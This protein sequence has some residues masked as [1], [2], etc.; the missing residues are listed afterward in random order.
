[1]SDLAMVTMATVKAVYRLAG[2]QCPG[3]LMSIVALLGLALP[4]PDHSP[5]S[6]RLSKLTIV[7]PLLPKAGARHVVIDATAVN[8]DGEGGMKHPS[9]WDE[10]VTP[11]A[12][13]A[14]R[15]R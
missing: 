8:V 3:L 12:Q 11:V 14:P 7:L 15:S 10:Q 2:R 1:Y 6:H 13:T 9:A 4:V 5:R